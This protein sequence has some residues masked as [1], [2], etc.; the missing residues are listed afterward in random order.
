MAGGLFGL[1]LNTAMLRN[2]C[3]ATTSFEAIGGVA[4]LQLLTIAIGTVSVYVLLGSAAAAALCYGGI[5][6]FANTMFLA[7]R[8]QQGE[9]S[10]DLDAHRQLRSFYRSSLERFFVVGLLFAIGMGVLHLG[11]LP[12]LAGFVFSQ[13]SLIVFQFL[14][15]I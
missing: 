3:W 6:A 13:M 15:E 2:H 5:V 1:R 11:P 4:M 9:R 7:W 10:P 14:R 8:M 12:L